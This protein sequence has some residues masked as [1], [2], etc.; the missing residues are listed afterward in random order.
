VAS[1]LDQLINEIAVITG[2][3]IDEVNSNFTEEQLNQLLKASQCDGVSSI[4]PFVSNLEDISCRDNGSPADSIDQSPITVQDNTKEIFSGEECLE[5]VAE[6]NAEIKEKLDKHT[7][8]NI[9]FTRLEEFKENITPLEYYYAERSSRMA[10]ILGEFQPILA[11]LKRLRDRID[12]HNKVLIPNQQS[13]IDYQHSLTVTNNEVITAAKNEI[14]RINGIISE[15]KTKFDNQE[16][17]RSTTE[18]KYPLMTNGTINGYANISDPDVSQRAALVYEIETAI[19]SSKIRS[20]NENLKRYSE[21]IRLDIKTP[22]G[23][24]TDVISNPLVGFEIKFQELFVMQID[25][26]K[27]DVN[28]G[29]KSIYK[30]DYLIKNSPLL[31]K[32]SFFNDGPGYNIS[33]IAANANFTSQGSLYTGYYNKLQDPINNFFTLEERGLSSDIKLLDPILEGQSVQTKK[34]AGET[35]FISDLDRLQNFYKEFDEGFKARSKQ[36]RSDIVKR[37]LASVKGELELIARYDVE[38]LLSIGRVNLFNKSGNMTVIN[39]DG[40]TKTVGTGMYDGSQTAIQSINNA[41][42]VFTQRI[43]EL[44]E[45]INRIEVILEDLPTAEKI[46]ALL[47]Q[48]SEKCFGNIPPEEDACSDVKDIL[49]SD[50]FFES[51]SGIDPTLPNFSQLCYWKEFAKLATIQGLLPIANNPTTF[52]YWPVGL[53]IPTPATLIKIPLP[54]IWI[55]LIAISTPLGV[56]VTFLNV[57]GV[58]ISPVVFFLSASGYKQHLITVRGSSKKF[59][60]DSD[61]EL[62]K[63]LIQIPLSVQSKLDMI[64]VPTLDPNKLLNTKES[65]RISILQQ[66]LNDAI[67]DGDSVRIHKA[68]KEISNIKKH[69]VDK[70]KPESTKMAEAADKGE[71]AIDMVENIKK[72]LFKTMDDLGKPQTNRINKLKELAYTRIADLKR[73]KLV[74]MENG[75]SAKVKEIN[76]N[77]KSDGLNI[78]D[79]IFAYINDLLDY[80]DKI[81]FPTELLPKETDK[82]DPKPD[83]TDAGK[84]KAIELSS[85]NDKEFVSNQAATVK[86]MFSVN[87]AKYKAEIEAAIPSSNINISENIDQ[88][89]EHMKIALDKLA[90]KV[91][92]K[93]G[94]PTDA[95]VAGGKLRAAKDKVDASKDKSIDKR[96]E[97]NKKLNDTQS[98]LSKKMDSDRVKQ[99]LSMTPAII[100]SLAGANISIDPFAKCCPRETFSLGF[101]FPPLV[102]AAI[103]TATALVKDIIS[104]M[105]ESQLR[106]IFGGKSN[107]YQRDIRLGLLNIIKLSVPDTI[108]IP[109]PSLNLKAGIDMFSGILGALS[110]PQAN[111]PS[112]LGNQQLKKQTSLNLSIVK[113]IIRKGLEEYLQNNILSK[114]SQNL[115]TDFIYAS[116]NDIKAF[117]KKFIESMSDTIIDVLKP[118]YAVINSPLIKTAKGLNLNVLENTV[119]NFPPFGPVAKSLFIAKGQLKFSITKSKSQFVI[120]EDAIKVASTTLK[121]ALLP[122]VNNPVAGLMVAGAGVANSLDTI[123]A[124]HPILSADDIPPWERLTL[125]NILFLV[126][127]DE[128]IKTGADQVGFF[129][130]YL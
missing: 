28:T 114:N 69:A 103:D 41:N 59:G 110:M 51:L 101:P 62:I 122:I 121:S 32:H 71:T 65:S 27:F 75:E 61:D 89:R 76:E 124:I 23:P 123:K 87:I 96:N 5:S 48:K 42:L 63:P 54:Q 129:R 40:S 100:S 130:S 111:F 58:F 3:S 60:S 12:Y 15:D 116:Q 88:I 72:K 90:D 20:I 81:T 126:F 68:K 115:D 46:K 16:Q 78:D 107:I 99:T 127:L 77:L 97:A 104:N 34:E 120:N 31:F 13:R 30:E 85:S 95:S 118:Y 119:F 57:N 94:V 70:H 21:Y 125:K 93:G 67:A 35:Y 38:L 22:V 29:D 91:K 1:I 47:K 74:A 73:E 82:L 117:M 17:L 36:I 52:R 2:L 19:S 109:K 106:G 8:H 113:S 9:L 128:F 92:G 25:K 7:A 24:Y 56:V 4:V 6:V 79:K 55:P 112:I 50:P 98:E 49:G 66:K 45:E 44:D 83:A 108:S 37:E 26:E 53:V 86:N 11:E 102:A 80:F 43:A 39:P 33:N 105:P 14:E 64:K 10:V 18:A 84:D